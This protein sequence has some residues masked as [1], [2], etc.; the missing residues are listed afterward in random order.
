MTSDQQHNSIRGHIMSDFT[1][2]RLYWED[3]GKG[4]RLNRF[5]IYF[6]C[7]LDCFKYENNDA[8]TLNP[9]INDVLFAV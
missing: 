5:L 6:R 9:N 4:K 7:V 3:C 8:D 2:G 1:A